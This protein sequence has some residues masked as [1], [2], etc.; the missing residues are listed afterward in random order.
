VALRKSISI[1]EEADTETWYD[2]SSTGFCRHRAHRHD[3]RSN[4]SACEKD[5]KGSAG[6]PSHSVGKEGSR[7]FV[8]V[9]TT[10]GGNV[11]D[12]KTGELTS[13]S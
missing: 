3:R 2:D 4:R 6:T 9:R 11:I 12:R 10:A 7:V 5:L 8:N 1:G 13:G